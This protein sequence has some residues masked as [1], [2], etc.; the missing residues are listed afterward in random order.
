MDSFLFREGRYGGGGQAQAVFIP[1]GQMLRSSPWPAAFPLRERDITQHH[2]P[3]WHPG[4]F[5]A[6]GYA[7][8]IV[9]W[10]TFGDGAGK[11]HFVC[12]FQLA[13][14]GDATGY[15]GDRDRQ[16]F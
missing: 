2:L 15:C 16:I 5:L 14:E 8:V 13:A 3:H 9:Y 12:V 4:R 6:F 10:E 7:Y 1:G 11:S